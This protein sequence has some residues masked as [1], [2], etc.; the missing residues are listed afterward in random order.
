MSSKI[1]K[2]SPAGAFNIE[3]YETEKR[4]KKEV[5]NILKAPKYKQVKVR[6]LKR[7]GKRSKR[8]SKRSKKIRCRSKRFRCKST[9]RK[10]TKRKSKK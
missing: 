6:V 7:D 5:D 8:R 9:K 10:S 2:E 1:R 3:K 4:I